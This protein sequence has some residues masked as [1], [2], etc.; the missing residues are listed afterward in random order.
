MADNHY[1]DTALPRAGSAD[2]AITDADHLLARTT[3]PGEPGQVAATDDPDATRAEIDRTR[4]R[5]S[6][7][8][9]SIESALLRKKEQ[10]Q[11]RLDVMAPVRQR[12]LVSV[13]AVF[14]ASLVLGYLTGGGDDE[15]ETQ[16]ARMGG[17]GFTGMPLPLAAHL[18]DDDAAM[19]AELWEKRARR[20]LRVARTQEE[21]LA[22]LRG[23]DEDESAEA[24]GLRALGNSASEMRDGVLSAVAGFLTE[25]FEKLRDGAGHV[26]EVAH[27]GYDA[28]RDR[29]GDGLESLADRVG[30]LRDRA[31]DGFDT[32]RDRAP[33]LVDAVK[34]KVSDGLDAVKDR[35]EH[36]R[37]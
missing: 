24:T 18:D 15:E 20:L 23:E 32:A 8:L 6:R 35:V 7:T 14:G 16:A 25:A 19:R 13:G 26:A 5:M 4:A 31:T 27:D 3:S 2:G 1:D 34:E 37:D 36:L 29:A 11:E 12:P 22:A 30:D 17:S 10:I 9:D 33:D 28:A 21:E